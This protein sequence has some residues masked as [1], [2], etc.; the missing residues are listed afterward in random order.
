[1]YPGGDAAEA[2]KYQNII[3]KKNTMPILSHFLLSANKKGS[4]II[5][6]DIE[7]ALKE[8]LR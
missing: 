4:Y 1:V 6:T 5:A 2:R 3:E 8:P 7:T